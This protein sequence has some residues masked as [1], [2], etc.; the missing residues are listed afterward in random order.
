MHNRGHLGVTL[1]LLSPILFY[2]LVNEYL[3]TAFYA[4]LLALLCTTLPDI[5]LKFQTKSTI[6]HRTP[7]IRRFV[8]NI[9]H[10]GITH[11]IWFAMFIGTLSAGVSTGLLY[12]NEVIVFLPETQF[13]VLSFGLGFVSVLFH[14]VGDMITPRGINP[15]HPVSYKNLSIPVSLAGNRFA[16]EFFSVLGFLLFIYTM[17]STIVYYIN[18]FSREQIMIVYGGLYASILVVFLIYALGKPRFDACAYFIQRR[19]LNR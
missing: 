5:D 1:I 15:I 6:L 2:L 16:N 18:F 10:R 14:V 12:W 3:F 7:V 9:R 17:G 13:I 11:T 4:T 19:L 8:P